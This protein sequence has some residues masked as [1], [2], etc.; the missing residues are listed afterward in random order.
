[1]PIKT[2]TKKTII[3]TLSLNSHLTLEWCAARTTSHY[4]TSRWVCYPSRDAQSRQ[5]V[6][7]VKLFGGNIYM[8]GPYSKRYIRALLPKVLNKSFGSTAP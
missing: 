8:G 2:I 3:D 7:I 4:S 5:R 6:A 1:M